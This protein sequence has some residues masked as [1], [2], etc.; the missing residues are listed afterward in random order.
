MRYAKGIGCL[1]A[2]LLA[3]GALAVATQNVGLF[4]TGS[5]PEP[6]SQP[7]PQLGSGG[8][9]YVDD[10]VICG[11]NSPCYPTIQSGV[12]AASSGDTVFVYSGTYYEKVDINKSLSV[13]GE[14]KDTT[15]LNAG[16]YQY[17]IYIEAVQVEIAGFTIYNPGHSIQ[18]WYSSNIALIENL[19]YGGTAIQ[20]GEGIHL[21]QSSF[22]EI[23]CNE[24][25]GT[26]EALYIQNS[27]NVTVKA[28]SMISNKGE[29]VRSWVSND[30]VVVENNMRDNGYGIR[31][32]YSMNYLIYHNNIINNT[33]QALD[34]SPSDNDWHHPVLLEGNYWS[35][36]AGLDDGSGTGK[37][38]IGG[39][40]I[41][42]TMI[43]HPGLG[44][45][46]YPLMTPH[47]VQEDCGQVPQ[48]A[49]ATVDI[50]PNTMNP[51]SH[52]K[53]ITCYIE[54]PVGYD[55]ADIDI[56]SLLLNG[57]VP[58]EGYPSG[59]ADHDGDGIP[60]L[61][62]KFP[63][64]EVQGVL[65]VGDDVEITITGKVG[66]DDLEGTDTIRVIDK[67]K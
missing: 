46:F 30:V 53:W 29:G 41:G 25:I 3:V 18:V 7:G 12:T 54:L 65:D 56:S 62:V 10:D 64:A 63:R 35:D 27:D 9:I 4:N 14:D 42:D 16:S 24:L 67:G 15:I 32:F 6:N 22:V 39:D 57:E 37:H 48:A 51:K 49:M 17:G 44:F 59:I 45:D 19:I 26:G 61:M 50:D 23:K 66:Q 28:N 20:W 40:G 43:P 11:G 5:S 60:D 21:F 1:V 8:M 33:I 55:V 31:L 47:I 36:Y 58:A 13:Y 2:I 52:G 34:N 38:A